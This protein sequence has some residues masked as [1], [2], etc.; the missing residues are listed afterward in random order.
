MMYRMRLIGL[1]I[2]MFGLTAGWA[3]WAKADLVTGTNS[4]TFVNPNPSG[5]PIVTTGVGTS[6]FTWGQGDPPAS[7]ILTYSAANPISTQTGRRH[8]NHSR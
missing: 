8:S 2:A 6:H 7:E 5:S 4:G 3:G 1:S